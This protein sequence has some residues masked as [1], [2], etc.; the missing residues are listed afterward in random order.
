MRELAL[1]LDVSR[2]TLSVWLDR[3]R[4]FPIVSRGTNGQK[5]AFDA[6][7]VFDFLRAKKAEQA[8][9]STARDEALAQLAFPFDLDGEDGAA[10]APGVS[11]KDQIEAVRLRRL[12]REEAMAS[13]V[14]VHAADVADTL[15]A[16]FAQLNR[17][18]HAAV[19]RIGQNH[20][21]PDAVTRS[22]DAEVTEA[23][24]VFVREASGLMKKAA[25]LD[26]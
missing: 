23:Q 11:I 14:L 19:R 9:A 16:C 22:M 24:R 21:L 10:P 20:N 25:D 12:Q 6:A 2:Q 26:A 15:A 5:Y 8:A 3:W 13:G 4:D 18:L 1:Q 17:A 7:A